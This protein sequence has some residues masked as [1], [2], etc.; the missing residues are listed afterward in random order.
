MNEK[1][2]GCCY[3][4]SCCMCADGRLPVSVACSQD[5]QALNPG[6]VQ[7]YSFNAISGT[8]DGTLY[9]VGSGGIIWCLQN[10]SW[11]QMPSGTTA[12]LNGVWCSSEGTVYAVGNGGT[13]L[14]LQAG[15]WA[16]MP[17]GTTANLMGI[18]GSP[19]GGVFIVGNGGTILRL[20]GATGSPCQAAP[21]PILM[22]CGA[23][24]AP[25]CMPWAMAAPYC[26]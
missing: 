5:W 19:D 10:S 22:L 2:N 15:I 4:H 12:N 14:R 18:Y 6:G 3:H 13:I 11:A 26:A 17:S 21:Q 16:A 7:E 8:A 24:P 1:F 25:G 9:A 23:V 20:Q